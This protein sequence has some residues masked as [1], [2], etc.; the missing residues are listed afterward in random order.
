V[1]SITQV[2]KYISDEQKRDEIVKDLRETPGR[3]LVFAET[4]R[5][6]DTLARFLFSHGFLATGIHGDRN[7]REREAALA[8][9]K[10]G[11]ISVLV[12]TD[13]ASRGLDISEVVQVINYDLPAGID[14]YVHRIGRTGRAGNK[15]LAVSY[16]ND[17]N[18]A[19]A[20]DLVS[21]LKE[22][23]QT[24]PDWL[25]K[26][27]TETYFKDKA[28]RRGQGGPRRHATR[29]G[30]YTSAPG[31]ASVMSSASYAGAAQVSRPYV[32]VMAYGAGVYAGYGASSVLPAYGSYGG[33]YAAPHVW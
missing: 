10:S 4:K 16:Y 22:A 25:S 9:F 17:G 21:T 26:A 7:Q 14:S 19:L 11:R 5:D 1:H 33:A 3:A 23:N 20:K 29:S 30:P 28:R 27:S 8:S 2:V 31:G 12:A 18:R 24:I 6:T 32:P 15:G 13:V